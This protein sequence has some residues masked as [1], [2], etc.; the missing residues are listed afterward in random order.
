MWIHDL[1]PY[2]G[3]AR[4][5]AVGWLERGRTYSQGPALPDVFTKLEVLL[6]DPWQP[7]VSGGVHPCDLCWYRPEVVGANNVFVPGESRVYVAPELILHYM[8]AHA[9]SPPDPFCRAVLECPPM[10]SP[11]YRRALLAAGGPGFLR[12][13]GE[14]AAAEPAVAADGASPRR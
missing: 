6:T 5:V 7:A 1:A 13:V 12:G 8:N 3:S 14:V 9:Y 4:C 11:E 2:A 10:R